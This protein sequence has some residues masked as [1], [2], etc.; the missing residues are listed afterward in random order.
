[1]KN[2]NVIFILFFF[3]I[4]ALRFF[5]AGSLNLAPDE[6]YYWFW[7]QHPALS[8][9]DHPPMVGYLIKISTSVF[10]NS[11]WAVRL[12]ALLTGLGCSY[13]VYDLAK[14]IFK[15]RDAGILSVIILNSLLIFSVGMV[16]ITPDSPLI[17]FWILTL[18]FYHRAIYRD[19]MIDWTLAGFSFGLGLLSKYTMI[20]FLPGLIMFIL[21]TPQF[22]YRILS[23]RLWVSIGIALL[24][25]TPVLVWNYQHHWI[26]LLFQYNHGTN[27][28]TNH[29]V[30]YLLEFL[31]SQA[32]LF[33]PFIF[34][35]LLWALWKSFKIRKE[36]NYQFSYLFW[37]VFPA[38]AFFL[39]DSLHTKIE[40][41]WA[42]FT[43]AGSI[44]LL[45][46]FLSQKISGR[47]KKS[48]ILFYTIFM[49]SFSLLITTLIHAQP[50][51]KLIPLSVQQDRTNDL[52]GW[53]EMRKTEKMFPEAASMP[54]L[55]TSHTL[56]GEAAF[57][58][59]NPN[60]YQWGAPYR[61]TDL[62]Q[63]NPV[64]PAG[65]TFLLLSCNN[66]VFPDEANS[67]FANISPLIDI[68]VYYSKGQTRT[69]IRTYHFFKG[70]NFLGLQDT[71]IK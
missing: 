20:F 67:L 35:G 8:Y 68:P 59:N 23:L 25:F 49:I 65:A 41:N 22:R 14:Q 7:S 5:F 53:D 33:S 19:K 31:G 1:M 38:F 58:L 71:H 4:T 57:Y 29:G 48:R 18:Y 39:Y 16:I 50:F 36:N 32:G 69:L 64:P 42:V 60:V 46:G 70:E 15:N 26:S 63:A 34:P 21:L 13:L 37:S 56:T 3:L 9:F 45:G 11:E 54:V 17:F 12:P 10:G 28:R 27:A 62:T 51:L 30:Q 52:S 43:H 24:I 40:G 2:H 61:I 6:S 66:D 47:E 44:I 55:T